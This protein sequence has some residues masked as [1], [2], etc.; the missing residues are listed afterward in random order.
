MAL[1]SIRTQTEA[2]FRFIHSDKEGKET[3]FIGGHI[4]VDMDVG[5][6]NDFKMEISVDSWERERFEY[7]DM[8]FIPGTEFGGV[9]Y[10][11][12]SCQKSRK[13]NVKGRTWRG[14]LQKKIVK[15]P[16]ESE[17]LILNGELNAVIREMIGVRFGSLFDVPEMDTGVL[18]KAWRVD[19]YVTLLEALEKLVKNHGCKLRIS[20]IE[21]DGESPFR[22]SVAAEKTKDY[23]N[24]IEYSGKHYADLEVE[25]Y[26]GGVNHLIC[27][28]EG[29]NTERIVLD[30]YVRKNGIIGERQEY[31]DAE[32]I[33]ELYQYS[34]ANLE[35]LEKGGIKRLTEIMNCK[36]VKATV[37]D[38]DI[39]IGDIV[40]GYDKVTNT[41]VIVPI[42]GKVL[43]MKNGTIKIEHKTKGDR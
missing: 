11:I 38:V 13:I 4:V 43:K 29:Q 22:I 28:G 30:L 27:V 36:Q 2:P 8:V 41:N 7:K 24:E 1:K 5:T 12:Q 9:V 33:E 35:E 10:S 14:L 25:E 34:S 42:V 18:V 21:K 23:S 15:P 39:E 26:K 16:Q 17:Y 3:G 31:F 19:R 6:T 20:S 37:R 32:E 40:A